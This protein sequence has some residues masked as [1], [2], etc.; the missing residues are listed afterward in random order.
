MILNKRR[1]EY[2]FV[3]VKNKGVI[4]NISNVEM[5]D[6]CRNILDLLRNKKKKET[7]SSILLNRVS[8]YTEILH[9]YNVQDVREVISRINQDGFWWKW[10][11]HYDNVAIYTLTSDVEIQLPIKFVR[12]NLPRKKSLEEVRTWLIKN[13]DYYLETK[14]FNALRCAYCSEKNIENKKLL[15]ERKVCNTFVY[16]KELNF[17]SFYSS[18]QDLLFLIETDKHLK[19]LL[20]E[21]HNCKH[22]GDLLNV[23]IEKVDV[24]N[25]TAF[26]NRSFNGSIVYEENKVI[27]IK[28]SSTLIYED[29]PFIIPINGFEN[30]IKYRPLFNNSFCYMYE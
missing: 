12:K 1:C 17:Y 28:P 21:Y 25:I 13:F 29:N 24:F 7:Y 20:D 11:D 30:F 8:Q 15:I 10:T 5:Q 4:I 27:G 26:N 18:L 6:E 22:D 23:W 2:M 14:K 16:R 19:P 9:S 3:E